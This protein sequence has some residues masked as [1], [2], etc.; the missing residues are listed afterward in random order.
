STIIFSEIILLDYVQC[1]VLFLLLLTSTALLSDEYVYQ[2]EMHSYEKLEPSLQRLFC[3]QRLVTLLVLLYHWAH[4]HDV[5]Q[6]A[7]WKELQYSLT[8]PWI[9]QENE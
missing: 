9:D 5:F 8:L 3:D 7:F 1:L 6:P 2:Q 4:V